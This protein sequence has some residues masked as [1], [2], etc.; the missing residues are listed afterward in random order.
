MT[1]KQ[2]PRSESGKIEGGGISRVKPHNQAASR[3]T[4]P[5][6]GR[7]AEEHRQEAVLGTPVLRAWAQ[8]DLYDL[9]GL[10]SLNFVILRIEIG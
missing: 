8:S 2:R 1:I 4:A 3:W 6:P 10:S 5:L 7:A 9:L